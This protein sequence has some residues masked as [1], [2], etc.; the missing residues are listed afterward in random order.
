MRQIDQDMV[1]AV[2]NKIA[3]SKSNTLT[4]F[5]N[6]IENCFIYLHGN[7]IATY[8][9]ADGSLTLKDGGW[10]S[11]TTKRRL[12]A[13]LSAFTFNGLSVVQ[14]NWNWFIRD[15]DFN[16]TVPFVSGMTV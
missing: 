12:N 3:W 5:D 11:R 15:N 8:K 14:K 9:Y 6:T 4:T 10:R 16:K 13:L 1:N 7:H 2:R